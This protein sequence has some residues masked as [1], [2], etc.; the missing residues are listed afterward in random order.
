MVLAVCGKISA[1]VPLEL[2]FIN[3]CNGKKE[4]NGERGGWAVRGLG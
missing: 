1:V 4:S 2:F 3:S